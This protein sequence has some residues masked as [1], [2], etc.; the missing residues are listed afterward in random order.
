MITTV[1]KALA[2]LKHAKNVLSRTAL[3]WAA[4]GCGTKTKEPAFTPF[5]QVEIKE[6]PAPGL[7][8]SRSSD[9]SI[10]DGLFSTKPETLPSAKE[11]WER[12]VKFQ[13]QTELDFKE[14][15]EKVTPPVPFQIFSDVTTKKVSLSTGSFV[16]VYGRHIP[17]YLPQM[18]YMASGEYSL[19]EEII[20]TGAKSAKGIA[21]KTRFYPP[22]FL[23]F[24]TL[25]QHERDD[26]NV[27]PMDNQIIQWGWYGAGTRN[28]KIVSTAEKLLPGIFTAKKARLRD[29]I[30]FNKLLESVGL[31][32]V[33]SAFEPD[34]LHISQKVPLFLSNSWSMR[35]DDLH[36]SFD[37]LEASLT[38]DAKEKL[39]V[40]DRFYCFALAQRVIAQ[41]I[42]IKGIAYAPKL[43]PD[44]LIAPL[45][46]ADVA[47]DQVEDIQG[48]VEVLEGGK[49]KPA[50]VS[51]TW[52]TQFLGDPTAGTKT[53]ELRPIGDDSFENT[54]D[55]LHFLHELGSPRSYGLWTTYLEKDL[56][57][58]GMGLSA[59]QLKSIKDNSIE[60]I[61]DENPFD[62][63]LVEDDNEKFGKLLENMAQRLSVFEDIDNDPTDLERELFKKDQRALLGADL[64][65]HLTAFLVQAQL[66]IHNDALWENSEAGRQQRA[67]L[68][69]IVQTI[70]FQI[71]NDYLSTP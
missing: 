1:E 59:A 46:T 14:S 44:G 17:R 19:T 30:L 50:I 63:K 71:G 18:L 56:L 57:K 67:H 24:E 9:L 7:I 43:T 36:T 3:L 41:I 29:T 20:S 65:K 55:F 48:A 40:S 2:T 52:L 22:T 10:P 58:M 28:E 45:D 68:S 35:S 4:A 37:I 66:R 23:D 51:P 32:K 64:R 11:Y 15:K 5:T 26:G 34:M 69:Q 6:K 8:S 13:T 47:T 42:S 54:Q 16:E 62:I 53:P 21:P 60:P 70:G 38:A 49:W 31:T 12:L 61:S 33:W 39:S 27:G 25:A